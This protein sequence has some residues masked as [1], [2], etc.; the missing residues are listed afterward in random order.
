MPAA[1]ALRS[2]PSTC[3][4]SLARSP[5]VS[6]WRSACRICGTAARIGLAASTRRFR[7][8]S[9]A[10]SAAAACR[11]IAGAKALRGLRQ[12]HVAAEH[13]RCVVP[14]ESPRVVGGEADQALVV[15]VAEPFRRLAVA[16][17]RGLRIGLDCFLALAFAL[18][19]DRDLIL[20]AGARRAAR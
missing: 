3:S 13:A 19:I 17:A 5:A 16:T 10:R 4:R 6:G 15:D 1:I 9:P 11:S 8:P 14:F 7:P 20:V 18:E 2:K 12:R